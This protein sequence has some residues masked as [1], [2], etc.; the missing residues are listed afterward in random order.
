ML[1]RSWKITNTNFD[2]DF[3]LE[4]EWE[5]R[6]AFNINDIR[7]LLDDDGDFSDATILSTADGLTFSVGSIIVAGISPSLI[8]VGETKYITIASISEDTPL[9]ISL[10]KFEARVINNNQ[11]K[12][13][14]AT[15]SEV[16]NDYFTIERS[17]D[18]VNWENIQEIEGAGNSSLHLDYAAIDRNPSLGTSYYRLKQTDFDDRYTYSQLK[19]VNVKMSRHAQVVIS[20]NPAST[21]ILIEGDEEELSQI[22]I[23]NLYGQDVTKFTPTINANKTSVLIDLT[24]LSSGMYLVKTRT[25][26]NKMYKE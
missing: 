1:F 24:G 18:A 20:P 15:A 8:P 14:W 3:S 19:S 12:L 6:G 21:Q 13:D 23:C 5:E 2:D 10:V 4:I 26:A 9:P 7:L 22:R 16:N 17:I 25:S 11:V